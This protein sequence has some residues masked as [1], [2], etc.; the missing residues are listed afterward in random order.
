MKNLKRSIQV[1]SLFAVANVFGQVGTQ[2]QIQVQLQDQNQTQITT[3]VP[4]D[5][6]IQ[7][8]INT[9]STGVEKVSYEYLLAHR[10]YMRETPS[11]K[12]KKLAMLDIGT[13]MALREISANTDEING[14]KSN[15]YKVRMGR[16]EG[17]IWG[18]MIAQKTFGSQANYDVKFVYGLE[19]IEV[20]EEGVLVKKHQLR[21]FK[22]GRQ[23]DK[24]VFDGYGDSPMKIKNIGNKGLFNV[25]DIL[26]FNVPNE[27]DGSPIGQLYVFWNNG[28]F[29]NVASLIDYSDTAYAKSE[30]FVF[31]SD[32]EGI[33]STIVLET[34][35]TAFEAEKG[36]EATNEN[37]KMIA[38]FYIWDGY[39]LSQKT[40]LPPISMDVVSNTNN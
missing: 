28:K 5:A 23:I 36:N 32:M 10:V 30:E 4:N 13:K 40:A 25:E 31:P 2:E 11:L 16:E 7:F 1:L 26:T 38:S 9:D 35:I 18:G 17:W 24:I 3:E 29:T 39:K 37:T 27:E 6:H 12:G 22:D 19:S 15:W 20:N 21:A 14:V 8:A 34:K 33:K